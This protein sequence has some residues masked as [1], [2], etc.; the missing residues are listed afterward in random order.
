MSVTKSTGNKKKTVGSFQWAPCQCKLPFAHCKLPTDLVNKTF[1]HLVV[2]YTYYR[3]VQ[4]GVG[5]HLNRS[6]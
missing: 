2:T 4:A 1:D 5:F 6:V 3:E